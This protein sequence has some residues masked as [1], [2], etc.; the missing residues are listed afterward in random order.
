MKYNLVSFTAPHDICST[1]DW[2][3]K[4]G[5]EA[6]MGK[7][8]F[9]CIYPDE[10]LPYKTR[11]TAKCWCRFGIQWMAW[12]NDVFGHSYSDLPCTFSMTVF[13]LIQVRLLCC[14]ILYIFSGS[15]DLFDGRCALLLVG[16]P[17][18]EGTFRCFVSTNHWASLQPFF[19]Q[20]VKLHC[21]V[22]PC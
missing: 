12:V 11:L 7:F 9:I 20:L 10:D 17:D 5:F 19:Y 14:I 15:V 16:P 8:S 1:R 18:S 13:S 22:L 3:E 6:L 4:D 21:F 2:R